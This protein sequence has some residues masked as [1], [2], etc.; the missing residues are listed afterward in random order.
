MT[1]RFGAR[2]LPLVIFVAAAVL[3]VSG[4]AL[5]RA[6][7]RGR[8]VV[9][10]AFGCA[11]LAAYGLVVNRLD[12]DFSRLLGTYVTIFAAASVLIG[13]FAFAERIRASTWLGLAIILIGGAVIHFGYRD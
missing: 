3:E 1:D 13:R 2:L 6:G 12:L 9:V 11:L 5:V 7:L 10:I 4:D 8:G